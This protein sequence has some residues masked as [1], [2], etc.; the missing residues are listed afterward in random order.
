M[1]KLQQDH[2]NC[3]VVIF[4]EI[5]DGL[6]HQSDLVSLADKMTLR[7]NMMVKLFDQ[8]SD[9]EKLEM[10][11]VLSVL[12]SQEETLISDYRQLKLEIKQ[13]ITAVNQIESYLE[14]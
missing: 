8:A 1:N 13:N 4:H 12:H 3:I 5:R 11:E 7:T 6:L 2:L 9:E 10:I 14:Y